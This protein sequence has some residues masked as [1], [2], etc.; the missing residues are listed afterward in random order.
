[1]TFKNYS[2]PHKPKPLTLM[3]LM[4]KTEIIVY[5]NELNFVS[6]K[7]TKPVLFISKNR[8]KIPYLLSLSR[9]LM[10]SHPNDKIF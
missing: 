5:H 6:Q 4:F 10:N 7:L 9:S 2:K 3:D 8:I 1:M